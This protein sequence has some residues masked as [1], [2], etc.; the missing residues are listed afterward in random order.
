MSSSCV[1]R[2]NDKAIG[3]GSIMGLNARLDDRESLLLSCD[4]VTIRNCW[5]YDAKQAAGLQQA[6]GGDVSRKDRHKPGGS[7][8]RQQSRRGTACLHSAERLAAQFKNWQ[9]CNN[10]IDTCGNKA[11]ELAECN[12]GLIA[13]NYMTNVVDGPQVIFGSR[14]VQIR[15]NEVY[16]TRTGINITE[17]LKPHPCERQPRRASGDINQ[18]VANA[19]LVFRTEPLPLDTRISYV[20]V[21]GIFFATKRRDKGHRKVHHA[22]GIARLHL[23]GDH[24]DRQCV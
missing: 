6:G 22:K 18:G 24:D 20:V 5:I 8:C 21:T 1:T 13:D 17:G 2:V 11:V 15:D 9:V 12:G 23:R 4:N 3:G 19:C 16:F 10:F 14:N 7:C